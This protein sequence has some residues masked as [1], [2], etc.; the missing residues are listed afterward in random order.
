MDEIW[1]PVV[2]FEGFYEVSNFGSV[3]SVDR[4]SEYRKYG[5]VLTRRLF[6]RAMKIKV[7]DNGY[8]GVTLKATSDGIGDRYCLVHRLVLEAFVGPCP[9]G[10]QVRHFPDRSK[11]NN[12]LDNLSWGTP[13]EN[14]ADRVVHGSE[15][16]GEA[17]HLAKLTAEQ[18]NAI[19][20]RLDAGEQIRA[21]AKEFGISEAAAGHIKARR[22]WKR[23]LASTEGTSDDP[24]SR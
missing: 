7:S 16:N 15:V 22:S 6:G 11:Q 21:V 2:G 14:Q 17:C 13:K 24:Y 9:T 10:Q 19:R 5:K 4:L 18:A 20:Q 8:C 3:R 23:A 12:R 1:K